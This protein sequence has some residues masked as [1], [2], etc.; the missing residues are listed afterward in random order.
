MWGLVRSRLGFSALL[1]Q[2]LRIES[3]RDHGR[4]PVELVLERCITK[5]HCT[6]HADVLLLILLQITKHDAQ[7]G[8]P[9]ACINEFRIHMRYGRKLGLYH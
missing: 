3:R 1:N 7:D 5:C 2:S 8:E 9:S 4:H 6:Y